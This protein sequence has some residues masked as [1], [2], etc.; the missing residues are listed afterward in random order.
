MKIKISS[1]NTKFP[2]KFLTV[3]LAFVALVTIVVLIIPAISAEIKIISIIVSL[4][5]VVNIFI[6]FRFH[7][8]LST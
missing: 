7:I 2:W 1:N 3:L 8:P 6:A 4:L 5:V